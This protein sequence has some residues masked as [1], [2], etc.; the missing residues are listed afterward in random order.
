M[1]FI[2]IQF[3]GFIGLFFVILSFQKD[4]RSFTLISQLISSVFFMTHYILLNAWTG[5]AMNLIS[6]LR[7]YIF[8]KKNSISWI[9]HKLIMYLFILLFW[10]GS[11]LTWQG[12]ISLLPAISMSLECIAL[13]NNKTKNMRWLM[14]LARPGW[15]TYSFLVGS[16]AGIA[17]DILITFSIIGSIIR[18]DILKQNKRLK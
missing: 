17:T 1:N 14:L 13:W 4:K 10:I 11:F 5:A 3:I 15:I 8:Y 18:F 16:Y 7:A 9:D 2:L 12:Y 6:T